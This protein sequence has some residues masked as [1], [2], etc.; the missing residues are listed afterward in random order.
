MANDYERLKGTIES[1][2]VNRSSKKTQ[3]LHT[4]LM[5]IKT[6]LEKGLVQKSDLKRMIFQVEKDTIEAF[7]SR[8]LYSERRERIEHIK[9]AVILGF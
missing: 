8:P 7:R 3:N 9:N 4:V 6:Y 1:Y 2:V 5:T